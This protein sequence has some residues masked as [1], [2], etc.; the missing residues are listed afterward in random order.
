MGAA[1]GPKR[2]PQGREARPAPCVTQRG[3]APP[4]SVRRHAL[5]ERRTP[6]HDAVRRPAPPA[7]P[8]SCGWGTDAFPA[9]RRSHGPPPAMRAYSANGRCSTFHERKDRRLGGL[10]RRRLHASGG[11]RTVSPS[12]QRHQTRPVR[13]ASGQWIKDGQT[14]LVSGAT[15]SGKS[16]LLC[17]LGHQA[18]RLGISTR[19]YRVSRLLDELTLARRGRFVSQARPAARQDVAP[20]P[21]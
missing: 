14:V 21:R 8:A 1:G 11:H 2:K 3:N 12:G 17:A 6:L 9:R 20:R 7:R 15:G 19:Y 5:H 16:Y 4:R 18:C 13:L 10:A